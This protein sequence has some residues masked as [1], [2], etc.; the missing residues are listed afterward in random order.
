[1]NVGGNNKIY[2]PLG[3]DDPLGHHLGRESGEQATMQP[4]TQVE[5]HGF[6]QEATLL[7]LHILDTCSHCNGEAYQ[8]VGEAEDR[9]QQGQQ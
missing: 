1:M 7:K 8:P 4:I 9:L 2:F 3:V 6:N 5:S